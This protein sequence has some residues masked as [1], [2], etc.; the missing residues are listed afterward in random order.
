MLDIKQWIKKV[1]E[2]INDKDYTG[3]GTSVDLMGYTSLNNAYTAPCDGIVWLQSR[4]TNTNYVGVTICNAD[5]SNSHGFQIG[6]TGQ[7]NVNGTMPMLKG[8]KA[9]RS[10]NKGQYNLAVFIPLV[11]GVV[12]R[13]RN[14]LQSLAYRGGWCKCCM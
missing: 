2:W 1:T 9:Y 6:G 5:G 3:Y 4:Y 7:A 8:Q 14:T 10:S 11:G 12:H 13:L